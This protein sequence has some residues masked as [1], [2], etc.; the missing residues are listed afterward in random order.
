MIASE[1]IRAARA[2]LRMSVVELAQ[3]SAVGVATIKRLEAGDGVPS[4]NLKTV[5]AL[6][7]ALEASGIEFIGSPE[8]GPGVRLLKV[9]GR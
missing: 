5:N 7:R 8:D 1:Q 6:V 2:L 9:V 4:A 3:K